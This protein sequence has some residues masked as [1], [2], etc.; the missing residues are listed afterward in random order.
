MP[1]IPFTQYLRPDG[2]INPVTIDVSDEVHAKAMRI[3]A[4]G[5][6]F[7]CEHLTPGYASLTIF[8]PEDEVDV[9]IEVVPNGPE[10]PEAVNRMVLGFKLEDR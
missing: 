10:V 9:A 7:E 5:Y 4:A 3:I 1:D 8:D 2:R 6:R